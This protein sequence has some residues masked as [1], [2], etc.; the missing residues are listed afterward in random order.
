SFD[1]SVGERA[2]ERPPQ[3]RE[4]DEPAVLTQRPVHLVAVLTASPVVTDRLALLTKCRRDRESDRA[5][6]R[7]RERVADLPV[8]RRLAALAVSEVPLIA[9]TCPALDTR[10]HLIGQL[11]D[12]VLGNVWPGGRV[13]D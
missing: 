1:L 12:K 3:A 2:A 8:G 5:R 10:D 6:H 11:G 13:R 7:G 9:G 4:R